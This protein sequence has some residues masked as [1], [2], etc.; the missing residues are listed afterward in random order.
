MTC[1]Q[2]GKEDELVAKFQEVMVSLK[3]VSVQQTALQSFLSVQLPQ[4]HHPLLSNKNI[5]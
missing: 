5:Q 4:V 2:A 3:E 1:H